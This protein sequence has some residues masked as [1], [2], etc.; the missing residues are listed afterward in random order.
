MPLNPVERRLLQ[1]R[2]HWEVF[3]ADSSKRLLVWRV[4][5]NAIRLTQC[6]CEMQK[7]ETEY[8]SKDLFIVFDAPFEH[9]IQYSRALKAS[10]AGQYEASRSDLEGQGLTSDWQLDATLPDSAS[11]FAQALRSLGSRHHTS[12]GQLV[13]VLMPGTVGSNEAY[14]SWLER[15]LAAGMPERLRLLTMDP[16]EAPRLDALLSSA[17]PLV[18]VDTLQIDALATA[19]ETF[20]QEAAV[21][22]AGVF[23]N[24]L[25]GLVTLVEKGSADQVKA[26]AIDALAFAHK[27]GWLDQEVVV[28]ILLAGALLKERRC[29]EAVKVYGGARQS[30]AAAAATGHPAGQQLVL[31]TWFGEAGARLAAGEVEQAALCYDEAAT[32]ARDIPN[33]ILAIEAARMAMFCHARMHQPA[34][35]VERGTTALASAELLKPDARVMTSLPL[36]AVDLLRVIEPERVALLEGVKHRLVT[37]ANA[38]RGDLERSAQALDEGRPDQRLDVLEA[39]FQSETTAAAAAATQEIEALGA[40]GGEQFTAVFSAVRELLLSD[41]PHALLEALPH[42]AVEPAPSGAGVATP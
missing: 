41:W 1:L 30:A 13:A 38:S 16:V 6:F 32:V 2:E 3:R 7:Y 10:L 17:H 9:S 39:T 35:A 33:P 14:A 36:A 42:A 28:R 21:G 15:C 26:K 37:R 40:G 25:M 8:S 31:Q 19:Q 18:A 23:R 27:Q 11:G 12:I 22:P 20:A 34:A 24:Y 5:D 29:D 4:P